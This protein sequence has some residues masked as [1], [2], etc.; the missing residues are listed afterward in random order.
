MIH[1]AHHTEL[2]FTHDSTEDC[3]KINV[4]Q[5]LKALKYLA[6]PKHLYMPAL[7]S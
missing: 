3:E 7:L 1:V 2:L 4:F 5:I 6:I